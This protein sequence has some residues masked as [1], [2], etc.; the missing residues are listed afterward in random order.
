MRGPSLRVSSA[1]GAPDYGSEHRSPYP[2]WTA[3]HR[4]P[5]AFTVTHNSRPARR[6]RRPRCT[7]PAMTTETPATRLAAAA[8]AEAHYRDL[9]ATEAAM[10][11]FNAALAAAEAAQP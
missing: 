5:S 7:I 8:A 2:L 3:R 9:A 1:E 10:E 6:R 4:R 11:R